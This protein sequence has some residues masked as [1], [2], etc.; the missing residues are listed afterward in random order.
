MSATWS[1]AFGADV[2]AALETRRKL[3]EVGG[4][5]EASV[6]AVGLIGRNVD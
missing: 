1:G 5:A 2:E 4:E 6:G 3:A